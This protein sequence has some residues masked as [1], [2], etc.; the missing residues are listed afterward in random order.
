MRGMLHRPSNWRKDK[1]LQVNTWYIPYRCSKLLKLQF[2]NN[3]SKRVAVVNGAVET[4]KLT[5]FGCSSGQWSSEI[6][7][8]KTYW[9][10]G[11]SISL[12]VCMCNQARSKLLPG[13][14]Q[15]TPAVE[16]DYSDLQSTITPIEVFAV[17]IPVPS[18]SNQVV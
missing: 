2:L 4:G 12:S 13:C 7:S 15:G 6:W 8:G 14:Q 11:I 3:D 1:S 16:C 18:S 10:R 9:Y 17:L 5:P